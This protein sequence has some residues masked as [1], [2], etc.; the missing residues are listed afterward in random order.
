MNPAHRP[1][2]G[3]SHATAAAVAPG[4]DDG[5]LTILCVPMPA[6]NTDQ[7]EKLYN[8]LTEAKKKAGMSRYTGQHRELHVVRAKEN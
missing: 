5:P 6:P 8:A 3:L 1:A 2:Y 7:V 4:A